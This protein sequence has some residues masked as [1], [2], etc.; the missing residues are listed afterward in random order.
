MERF[1]EALS[2]IALS[3]LKKGIVN[4]KYNN[5]YPNLTYKYVKSILY[6]KPILQLFRDK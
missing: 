1:D 2:Y 5:S 4:I 6:E 3:Q